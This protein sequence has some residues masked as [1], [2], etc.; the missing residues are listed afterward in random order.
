M[1]AVIMLKIKCDL[2]H[3]LN[4]VETYPKK[5]W[6]TWYKQALGTSFKH[7]YTLKTAEDFKA[8]FLYMTLI[9]SGGYWLLVYGIRVNDYKC[10]GLGNFL[11]RYL[12]IG[13]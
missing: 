8:T 3:T 9:L 1:A 6:Q 7:Y 4:A 5:H 2:L 11:W 12:F 13:F 10:Y